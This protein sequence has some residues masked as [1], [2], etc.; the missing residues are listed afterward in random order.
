MH[1]AVR[2]RWNGAGRL[3]VAAIAFLISGSAAAASPEADA[4]AP[5]VVATPPG[6]ADPAENAK[7][8]CVANHE[9]AQVARRERR[10][11]ATRAAL[12]TCSGAA[13]PSAIR[14]DCVDWLDQVAAQHSVGRRHRARP[15]APTSWP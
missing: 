2:S 7:A 11:L 14:A 9:E 5:S 10:L 13:C 3:A 6:P 1:V 15:R 12:R 4:P 8:E